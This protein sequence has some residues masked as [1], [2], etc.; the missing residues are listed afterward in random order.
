MIG[1]CA[2]R[3]RRAAVLADLMPKLMPWGVDSGGRCWTLGHT[4]LGRVA[5]H[6]TFEQVL[7]A[8]V[9]RPG[10]ATSLYPHAV[11]QGHPRQPTLRPPRARPSLQETVAR[12]HFTVAEMAARRAHRRGRVSETGAIRSAT[13]QLDPASHH[14]VYLPNPSFGARGLYLTIVRSLGA[15]PRFHKAEMIA[16]AQ[17]LLAA[18]EQER[19]RSVVLIDEAHLLTPEQLGWFMHV[20]AGSSDWASARR[21]DDPISR[22]LHQRGASTL[23]PPPYEDPAVVSRTR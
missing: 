17:G 11:L 2:Y 14:V 20:P 9:V 5:D 8:L 21:L 6:F 3:A 15:V 4:R 10:S 16:Q 22:P 19:R 18:E 23:V 12:I 13:S 1:C 7:Q